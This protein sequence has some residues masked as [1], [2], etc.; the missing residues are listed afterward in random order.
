[1]RASAS[2][3]ELVSRLRRSSS[4]IT[5]A[6]QAATRAL[7]RLPLLYRL[8]LGACVLVVASFVAAWIHDAG[9][10]DR[11][12]RTVTGYKRPSAPRLGL[13]S[14]RTG[15]CAPVCT[16]NPGGSQNC[17][18]KVVHV[19]Y[20]SGGVLRHHRIVEGALAPNYT[21]RYYSDDQA[22]RYVAENCSDYLDTYECFLPTAYKA[23]VFRYCVLFR[24][25]GIYMDND[26]ALLVHPEPHVYN[27]SCGGVYLLAEYCE[28]YGLAT[29]LWTGI[30]VSAAKMPV[31]HCMLESVRQNVVTRFYGRNALDITGPELLARCVRKHPEFIHPIGW[32][33]KD[34]TMWLYPERN[35]GDP[36][37]IGHEINTKYKGAL[38]L[39]ARLLLLSFF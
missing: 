26:F 13:P 5:L 19:T 37:Q 35:K 31:W 27:V 17:I 14:D 7:R 36:L 6:P 18:P 28:N 16:E 11:A 24:E 23:D 22:A 32:N 25:G 39:W 12:Y 8:L 15:Q 20:N 21:F 9:L 2:A 1:M 4:Q 3:L 30:M 38:L 29:R 34:T 10:R 33:E